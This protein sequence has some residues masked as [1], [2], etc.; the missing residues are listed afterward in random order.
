MTSYNPVRSGRIPSFSSVSWWA[1]HRHRSS[2]H[3]NNA[4]AGL[5]TPTRDALLR[6]T[7]HTLGPFRA[8]RFVRVWPPHWEV[9]ALLRGTVSSLFKV[10]QAQ[11]LAPSRCSRHSQGMND[12]G[13]NSLHAAQPRVLS[14]FLSHPGPLLQ[15]WYPGPLLRPL[16]M[17]TL[18]Q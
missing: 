8:D 17:H 9:T 18:A 11:G 14:S 10:S 6:P 5:P 12:S 4:D 3:C 13:N 16:G 15:P 2:T 1:R 7:P